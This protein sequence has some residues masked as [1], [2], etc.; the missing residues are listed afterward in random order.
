MRGSFA[1]EEVQGQALFDRLAPSSKS[2]LYT[3]L[4]ARWMSREQIVGNDD[5]TNWSTCLHGVLFYNS[6]IL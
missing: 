5:F 4:R 2:S 6:I 3:L 1:G